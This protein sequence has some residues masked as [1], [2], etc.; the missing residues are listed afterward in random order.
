V[1]TLGVAVLHVTT[2]DPVKLSATEREREGCRTFDLPVDQRKSEFAYRSRKHARNPL[3]PVS[4][5][6]G[7]TAS[8][9]SLHSEVPV[10][11]LRSISATISTGPGQ[12]G[13]V[14]I[15]FPAGRRRCR[16]RPGNGFRRF[17]NA[18]KP[19]GTT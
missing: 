2:K 9:Q 17:G 6:Y 15:D 12:V 16:E 11:G 18:D 5:R 19:S 8:P 3:F 14:E 10:D 13:V 4:R 1:R 7:G